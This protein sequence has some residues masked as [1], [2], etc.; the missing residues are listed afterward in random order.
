M[1]LKHAFWVAFAASAVQAQT[2]SLW[3]QCGGVGYTGATQCANGSACTSLNVYYAQCVPASS[4]TT[5]RTTTP[6]TTPS[7]TPATTTRTT[8]PLTT[9]ITTTSSIRTTTSSSFITTT[10]SRTTTSSS[11]STTATTLPTGTITDCLTSNDVPQYLPGSSN[12]NFE[13]KGFNLRIPF[14]PV[15]VAMPT[16]VPQVQAAVNC[17]ARYRLKIS[18][19]AGGHSYANHGIGGEDGHLMIN[20][21][22]INSVVLDTTTNVATVGPGARLGNVALGLYNQGKRA[23]SHGTC[24][25]VGVGGHVLHGGYGYSSH[26]RGL[27]LDWLIEAQVVLADGSLVTTSSTQNP[28]LFWAIKGAGGSFGIVVSMKFNTFP[29]PESNIVYSYSFSWTQAQGRASLEALQAYANSTQFPRELNLRFWVGV[30]NTQILGVYYGSRADFDTAIAPLL[31][32]LGTPSSSSISVMNWLD[33]LNNY[34]YATMSPPLDYDVHET[35]FAKSLM[36]TQLSPAALDAFVSYWFTASKP[37]RSWYMMIDIHGG[38]TSAISNITGEAGGSYAHRAAV[39]KYQFYDSV[40]GGGTYPSNGFDFLNGWVN[41]VTSVS[42]AN[43]WSMYINYADTSLSVN[44]YGNFYWR[45]NYPRLRSIKTTYDP[46][47]VFH[48]PQVVQPV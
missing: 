5:T 11:R 36:T 29:A 18:A 25:G 47:D 3:G 4:T 33:T 44:D 34:A 1:G 16:T 20:L 39:F 22:Y 15:A 6:A 37:S 10:S 41:S 12:F 19:K 35:F 21:K 28:D 48:N 24:P 14:T 9:P 17:G 30:F 23:I 40:F 38:P 13:A 2:Q 26:T 46:N 8:T 31:S 7:T 42:P 32:K 45:A 43:T 27:A